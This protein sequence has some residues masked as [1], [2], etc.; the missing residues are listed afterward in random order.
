M[1]RNIL[2]LG[3]NLILTRLLFPEAFALI[4]VVTMVMIALELTS[5]LGTM[6]FLVRHENSEARRYQDGIW[7][8][9]LIRSLLLAGLM[10]ASAP[11][12]GAWLEMPEIIPALRLMSLHFVFKAF[13]RSNR[14][15]LSGRAMKAKMRLLP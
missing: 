3:S 11:V 12:V 9:I 15:W 5:D 8:I 14:R 2:R 1:T 10:F 7:T 6:A 13:H 4:G